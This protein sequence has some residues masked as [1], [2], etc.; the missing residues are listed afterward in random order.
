[1]VSLKLDIIS[2]EC[3]SW[4][5]NSLKNDE[6]I[7]TSK[8]VINRIKEAFAHIVDPS[9]MKFMIRQIDKRNISTT[10][11]K[12]SV[13]QKKA[14]I[15]ANKMFE[16]HEKDITKNA[17]NNG[18]RSFRQVDIKSE[19]TFTTISSIRAIYFAD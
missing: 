11:P 3:L 14:I 16:F 19:S 4:T 17:K 1:M 7:P 2:Y 13:Y 5:L 18:P 15:E 6:L 10:L 12:L 9:V 8:S